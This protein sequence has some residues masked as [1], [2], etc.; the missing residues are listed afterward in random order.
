MYKEFYIPLHSSNISIVFRDALI[1]P[2][3]YIDSWNNDIQSNNK[4]AILLSY[5]PYTV[6]ERTSLLVVITSEECD[7]YLEQLNDYFFLFHKPIPISRVKNI[8]FAEESQINT[9]IYNIEQG[10]G[11]VP[12]NIIK[13]LKADNFS[14]HNIQVNSIT[15]FSNERTQW[16]NYNSVYNQLLGGIALMQIS[17]ISYNDYPFNFFN[18]ISRFNNKIRN[19]IKELKFSTDY[20]KST[21]IKKGKPESTIYEKID[22]E[23]VRSWALKNENISLTTKNGLINIESIPHDKHSYILAV[24]ATFGNDTGKRKTI[25]DFISSMLSYK[26]PDN[27]LEQLCLQFGINQG[28]SN[29]RNFYN[30]S[31]KKLNVKFKL[32]STIDYYIIESIYQ[33]IFNENTENSNFE[34]LDNWI[35]IF[36]DNRD[37]KDYLTYKVLDKYVIYKKKSSVGSLAYFGELYLLFSDNELFKG[38]DKIFNE[39]AKLEIKSIIKAI[40]SKVFSDV[41]FDKSK[42]PDFTY[43]KKKYEDKIM[44]LEQQINDLNNKPKKE[45]LNSLPTEKAENSLHVSNNML[46]LDDEMNRKLD[47]VSKLKKITELKTIAEFYGIKDGAKYSSSKEDINIIKRLIIEQIKKTK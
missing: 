43:E 24:L 1:S 7:E 36:H 12:K 3:K 38:F 6:S 26:F 37:F 8:C 20:N 14:I 35:P 42:N 30:I 23:A 46:F 40:Y 16:T 47:F 33:Y 10:N 29:F 25:D 9:T 44:L 22:F 13:Y 21:T 5:K 19:E 28:Y 31:G 41:N 34:Y 39:N 45:N 18:T 4:Q 32:N 27:K 2:V 15:E 17:N 11:F